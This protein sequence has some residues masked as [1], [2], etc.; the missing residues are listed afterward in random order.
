MF[1]ILFNCVARAGG[2]ESA[3]D[4]RIRETIRKA[5]KTDAVASPGNSISGEKPAAEKAAGSGGYLQPESVP[6]LRHIAQSL[7]STADQKMP[8]QPMGEAQIF[9][10]PP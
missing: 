5:H 1:N 4:W 10:I 3:D 6:P 8:A 7:D 9:V 2:I